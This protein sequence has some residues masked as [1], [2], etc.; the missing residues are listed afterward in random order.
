MTGNT[1]LVCEQDKLEHFRK[2]VD[3][4]LARDSG[5]L[6]KHQNAAYGNE[7]K[8]PESVFLANLYLSVLF[9]P[10]A[11]ENNPGGE[12]VKELQVYGVTK[13]LAA[14]YLDLGHKNKEEVILSYLN[15]LSA[16]NELDSI[17]LRLYR[18]KLINF[19]KLFIEE[20][21]DDKAEYIFNL[22][23][24][25][26]SSDE[27]DFEKLL[28]EHQDLKDYFEGDVDN[29]SSLSGESETIDDMF[30]SDVA[31]AGEGNSFSPAAD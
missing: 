6:I 18:A 27:F 26:E 22:Q 21:K 25:I 10:M 11:L 9:D 12:V 5:K 13:I 7:A 31:V 20:Y 29:F 24:R 1:T 23:E 17:Q 4:T 3:A 28:Q 15:S 19:T 30:R 16:E 8:G 14:L 2:A